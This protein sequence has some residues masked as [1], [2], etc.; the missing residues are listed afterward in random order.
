MFIVARL[1]LVAVPC[2]NESKQM[3]MVRIQAAY[4]R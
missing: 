1:V 3:S 2:A 4:D